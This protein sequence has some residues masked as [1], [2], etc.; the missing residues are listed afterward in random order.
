MEA[1]GL[2]GGSQPSLGPRP[3]MASQ[4]RRQ[5]MGGWW[6]VLSGAGC[7]TLRFEGTEGR[8]DGLSLEVGTC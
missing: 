1:V 2:R 7:H 6:G 5:Q 4:R 8:G 3:G